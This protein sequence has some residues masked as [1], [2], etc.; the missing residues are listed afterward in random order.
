MK[1]VV[2]KE[3]GE[4][5]NFEFAEVDLPVIKSDEVLI[6][7]MATAFNPLDYQMRKGLREKELMVGSILG[8]EFS[9]I[10]AQAGQDV[11]GFKIGDQVIACSIQK[12]SNGSYA[13]FI[14]LSFHELV[15]KPE[16]IDFEMAASIPVSGMTAWSCYNRMNYK[17]DERIFINGA[18]GGVGR[19]LILLLKHY[20]INNIVV[21]AGNPE[22]INTL[23]ELGILETNII[24][25]NSPD[26][27]Q[28]IL[29][30]NQGKEFD[31]VVDL[32][33]GEI[34]ETTA[35]VLKINGNYLDVTFFGTQ[36]TREIL[37]DKAANILNIAVYA[38]IETNKF[39]RIITELI[40]ADEITVPNVNVVGNLSA[41]TVRKAHDLMERNHTR[42]KK[43]VMVNS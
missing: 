18:S 36:T 4:V 26:F 21:T 23:K 42:G 3:F 41:E 22:S 43:L 8:V 9:G 20:K 12:G 6:R 7:I 39:L 2:L 17:A 15:H 35:R 11:K 27:E 14:A 28:L 1:T 24:D 33:G 25:Y 16:N 37:F 30:A 31:H 32:V 40:A 38:E 10:I 29:K 13:E 5:N 34:S 19:F